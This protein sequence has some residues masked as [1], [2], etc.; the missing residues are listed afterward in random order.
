MKPRGDASDSSLLEP[1]LKETELAR[2]REEIQ[3]LKHRCP[4]GP[5]DVTEEWATAKLSEP[6]HLLNS[7]QTK[8]PQLRVKPRNLLDDRISMTPTGE[9]KKR[10]YVAT[11]KGRPLSILDGLSC[12]S[13]VRSA[14]GIRTVTDTCV[15]L[16]ID[17]GQITKPEDFGPFRSLVA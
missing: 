15:V 4:E 3:G 10:H 16:R 1:S 6:S 13:E 9:G 5:L 12:V 8:I 7:Q 17:V 2:L 11:V 14:T